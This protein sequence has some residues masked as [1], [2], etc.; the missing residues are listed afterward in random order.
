MRQCKLLI[1]K[2]SKQIENLT[3]LT[4]S[5]ISNLIRQFK[6][7]FHFNWIQ[8]KVRWAELLISCVFGYKLFILR[9]Y[10]KNKHEKLKSDKFANK[11]SSKF[12]FISNSVVAFSINKEKKRLKV[13]FV[14]NKIK[15]CLKYRGESKENISAFW[16]VNKD[17]HFLIISD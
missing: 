5:R 15:F 11:C 17:T 12:Q 7:L 14:L 2:S 3:W 16:F 4:L 10:T 6:S 8:I 1:R 13:R 9:R